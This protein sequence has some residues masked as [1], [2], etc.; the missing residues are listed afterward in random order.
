MKT[1]DFFDLRISS[2]VHQVPT[3]YANN[4]NDSNSVIDLMFLHPD[5]V[6]VNSY[7]ILPEF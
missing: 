6:E 1:S 2:P 4:T 3:C 7:F 5:L